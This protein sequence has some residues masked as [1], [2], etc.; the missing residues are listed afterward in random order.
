MRLSEMLKE[1]KE[2]RSSSSLMERKVDELLDEN[3][4]LSS[5]VTTHL[6][7]IRNRKARRRHT[8][9]SRP[10]DPMSVREVESCFLQPC[11]PSTCR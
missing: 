9:V 7:S 2:F 8:N 3:G 10:T 5:Q 11:S 4:A 6:V 1:N